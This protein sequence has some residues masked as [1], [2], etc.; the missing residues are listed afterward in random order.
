MDRFGVDFTEP[1]VSM[2]SY[3]DLSNDRRFG[4]FNRKVAAEYG[5]HP[6]PDRAAERAE[7]RYNWNPNKQELALLE[8]DEHVAA[9]GKLRDTTGERVPTGGCVAEALRA[10]EVDT[11]PALPVDRHDLYISAIRDSRT[12]TAFNDWAT[13]M[14]PKGYEFGSPIEVFNIPWDGP[15]SDG[16]RAMARSH[17]DCAISTNMVGRWVSVLA[18]WERRAIGENAEQFRILRT[19]NFALM[20][21]VR[22][23]LTRIRE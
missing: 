22:E 15:V 11:L 8:P 4:L 7:H 21:R 19:S 12:G 1:P 16:E 6:P 17:V 5:F 20:D 2:S 23:V 13:C 14:G 18:A 3:D 10:L 9:A